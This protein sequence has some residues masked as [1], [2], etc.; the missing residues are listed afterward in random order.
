MVVTVLAWF[1]KRF[2]HQ[3]RLARAMSDSSFAVYVLH[4]IIIVPLALVLSGIP[5]NPTSDVS[6]SCAPGGGAV[7][8]HRVLFPQAPAGQKHLLTAWLAAMRLQPGLTAAG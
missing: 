5:I 3:G 7:L 6:D 4:P 8:H 1:R 2:N